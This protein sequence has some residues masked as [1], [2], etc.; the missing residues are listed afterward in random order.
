[1]ELVALPAGHRTARPG[2]PGFT[3]GA[4]IC[5]LLYVRRPMLDTRIRVVHECVKIES[6]LDHAREKLSW[7]EL[8]PR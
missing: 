8:E 7:I 1:M 4:I 6:V 2:R 3:Q 5:T